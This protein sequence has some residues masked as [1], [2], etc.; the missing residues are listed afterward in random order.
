M[1]RSREWR[2][3]ALGNWPC[4][5]NGWMG[6][7]EAASGNMASCAE[8]QSC[9]WTILRVVESVVAVRLSTDPDACDASNPGY[10]DSVPIVGFVLSFRNRRL[11]VSCAPCQRQNLVFARPFSVLSL[12]LPR[13]GRT[14]AWDGRAPT[15]FLQK[16]ETAECQGLE[17]VGCIES[18]C[19]GKAVGQKARLVELTGRVEPRGE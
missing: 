12:V 11:D 9:I 8:T 15:T 2:G 3:L 18:I 16:I 4:A 5:D 13:W 1:L 19:A 10:I 17:A 14:V 7:V 6:M